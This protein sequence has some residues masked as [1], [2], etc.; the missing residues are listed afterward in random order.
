[1]EE[2]EENGN[3]SGSRQQPVEK[4]SPG[5]GSD[6]LGAI[7]SN[8]IADLQRYQAE[9]NHHTGNRGRHSS[10][11]PMVPEIQFDFF[12]DA[13]VGYCVVNSLGRIERVNSAAARLLGIAPAALAN[14]RILEWVLPDDREC[15]MDFLER[16]VLGDGH[17]SCRITFQSEAGTTT[18][19]LVASHA[20]VANK[21]IG[22]ILL[23]I[24]PPSYSPHNGHRESETTTDSLEPQISQRRLKT[25][26]SVANKVLR[27]ETVQ[28]LL[29]AVA[30]GARELTGAGLGCSGYFH[31]QIFRTWAH[32]TAPGFSDCLVEDPLSCKQGG[33]HLELVN[34]ETSLRMTDEEL[35]SHSRWWGLPEGHVPLRGLLGVSLLGHALHPNGLIMLSDKEGGAHFTEEDEA[36][37]KQLAAIASLGLQHIEAR[38]E[39][40]AKADELEAVFSSLYNPAS[41]Y[42]VHGTITK[43]NSRAVELHG[44]NLV[45]MDPELLAAMCS[46]RY[47]DGRDV[48]AEELP[49][50]RAL[51]GDRLGDE[52]FTILNGR[53]ELCYVSISASPVT[54]NGRNE[55][56]IVVWH[57]ITELERQRGELQN[58]RREL[59]LKVRERTIELETANQALQEEIVQRSL[60]ESELQQQK[61]VLETIFNHI[62]VMLCFYDSSGKVI[63]IN[64][65]VE[66]ITGWSAD[67]IASIN[68]MEAWYPDPAYRQKV[69]NALMEVGSGWRDFRLMTRLGNE[70]ETSWA[71]VRLSDGSV[72]GIGIDITERKRFE[73]SFKAL[74]ARLLRAQEDERKIVAMELHDSVAASLSAIKLRL[75]HE[76]NEMRAG[77]QER[78][79][80]QET[81]P[82]IKELNDEVRRIMG[83]LRP[84]MLDDL[85]LLPTI[86]FHC[87]EV[88]K[89]YPDL[90]IALALEVQETDVPES[91]KIVIFRIL[92]E[93]LSNIAKHSGA[94]Q[95]EIVLRKSSDDLTLS[96][97]DDGRGFDRQLLQPF[98]DRSGGFGIT[99]MSERT[100]LSGGSFSIKSAEGEGTHIQA[101]WYDRP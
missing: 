88:Q 25:L 3:G 35:Y 61:E 38:Q 2:S 7:L 5:G 28:G 10:E 67:D 72:I 95:V 58:M 71:N 100:R 94:N 8:L 30:D 47:P 69:W 45:G 12:T 42:N 4:P 33:V 29:Q 49:A 46:I 31:N 13:P 78:R 66:S 73:R 20:A 40:E 84:A 21:E 76:L 53:E 36:V 34:N 43:A 51:R 19:V 65:S 11:Q 83:N 15:F 23:T 63:L 54:R 96:I 16:A 79:V 59:E 37:L 22:L 48:P 60:A 17:Q 81:I 1:M 52:R 75:E 90:T 70:L 41:V 91:R 86:R 82:L 89:F 24:F 64:E 26:L 99:S 39:V 80:M 85:G 32:S 6:S 93:A 97:T 27:E 57:D 50:R 92:Q 74:S 87:R 77:N 101:V 68:L 44:F 62:P 14:K 9:V 55:G 56:A 18:P 98:S